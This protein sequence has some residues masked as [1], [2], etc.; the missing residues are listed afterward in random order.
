MDSIQSDAPHASYVTDDDATDNETAPTHPK[1]NPSPEQG[2]ATL[3]SGEGSR[4]SDKAPERQAQNPLSTHPKGNASLRQRFVRPR[5]TITRRVH[6]RDS[7]NGRLQTRM[8]DAIEPSPYDPYTDTSSYDSRYNNNS[9]PT[10]PYGPRPSIR[11][12]GYTQNNLSQ[13]AYTPSSGTLL[14]SMPNSSQSYQS[15]SLWPQTTSDRGQARPASQYFNG[16]QSSPNQRTS[17]QPSTSTTLQN[18]VEASG[19]GSM[20]KTEM[21]R[22]AKECLDKEFAKSKRSEDQKEASYAKHWIEVDRQRIES[23]LRTKF[24]TDL[25]SELV[26]RERKMTRDRDRQLELDRGRI[27]A[28]LKTEL[29]MNMKL[30]DQT[31]EYLHFQLGEAA[32]QKSRL[33]AE[34][35]DLKMQFEAQSDSQAAKTAE[36]STALSLLE[37]KL[38]ISEE[39]IMEER[40]KKSEVENHRDILQSRLS[41][42]EEMFM[43]EVDKCGRAEK[44]FE[45]LQANLSLSEMRLASETEQRSKAEKERDDSRAELSFAEHKLALVADQH[46]NTERQLRALQDEISSLQERLILETGEKERIEAE[47]KRLQTDIVELEDRIASE[48][49]QKAKEATDLEQ[50]LEKENALAL[51]K[52]TD[53]FQ[54]EL[55]GIKKDVADNLAAESELKITELQEGLLTMAKHLAWESEQRQTETEIRQAAEIELNQLH[56]RM[57]YLYQNTN[58]LSRRATYNRFGEAYEHDGNTLYGNKETQR[59]EEVSNSNYDPRRRV[60]R[61]ER[62]HYPSSGPWHPSP[63]QYPAPDAPIQYNRGSETGESE[64]SVNDRNWDN[65]QLRGSKQRVT[66]SEKRRVAEVTGEDRSHAKYDKRSEGYAFYVTPVP[67]AQPTSDSDGELQSD[68]SDSELDQRPGEPVQRARRPQRVHKTS[69]RMSSKKFDKDL[70]EDTSW[71]SIPGEPDDEEGVDSGAKLAYDNNTLEH[72]PAILMRP[73]VQESNN[74]RRPSNPGQKPGAGPSRHRSSSAT[75]PKENLQVPSKVSSTTSGSKT[76]QASQS[77]SRSSHRGVESPLS[78]PGQDQRA[79]VEAEPNAESD[80]ED[81]NGQLLYWSRERTPRNLLPAG[82]QFGR[83]IYLV[84]N[85]HSR[86]ARVT[87]R[88]RRIEEDEN[89]MIYGFKTQHGFMPLMGVP[90]GQQIAEKVHTRK[91]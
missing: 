51:S 54:K 55:E 25:Q 14:P 32:E 5:G 60:R 88:G 85:P 79:L 39:K 49:Q 53:I 61:R 65:S 38:S 44:E 17:Q 80:D 9:G 83:P 3:G 29:D 48:I 18:P 66:R 28:E 68:G 58:P 31:E 74:V 89:G 90:F 8:D 70:R 52:L 24:E 40:H 35:A 59:L 45:L 36:S 77:E 21:E 22:I 78:S 76:P 82:D 50:R 75:T 81:E 64:A 7:A 15:H 63:P 73:D 43:S 6:Y 56:D 12:Y 11:G 46:Q 67:L 86:R 37:N 30:R 27:T 57:A 71:V 69:Q 1:R 87:K 34:L 23:D 72:G 13:M 42:S 84:P 19:T 16:I 47:C 4:P 20:S 41:I 62:N 2:G 26:R 33:E 10:M 91:T